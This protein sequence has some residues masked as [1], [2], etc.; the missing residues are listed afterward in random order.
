MTKAYAYASV[1]VEIQ[2]FDET[3]ALTSST[4]VKVNDK[5]TDLEVYSKEGKKI[6]ITGQIVKMDIVPNPAKN[7]VPHSCYHHNGAIIDTVP[8]QNREVHV[9]TLFT[10]NSDEFYVPMI[11]VKDLESEFYY[12]VQTNSIIS[13]GSVEE[14]YHE[15]ATAEDLA[16]AITEAKEGDLIALGA[17]ISADMSS[18]GTN[19][20][21]F[22]IPAGVNFD[23]K[24]HTI[25]IDDETGT[26]TEAS[27]AG[28]VVSV[29]GVSKISNLNI[30]GSKK[31]KAG[32]VVHGDGVDVTIE[33]VSITNCGTVGIQCAAKATAT[34][35]SISNSN[36]GSV[37]VD[38]GSGMSTDPSF[39]MVSGSL[40][41]RVQVYSEITDKEVITMPDNYKK[42]VGIG[43]NLKGFVYYT[44][45]MSKIGVAY[46][47]KDGVTYVYETQAD[48]DADE[49]VTNKQPIT[50]ESAVIAGKGANDSVYTF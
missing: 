8:I 9:A 12:Y 21:A 19:G 38:K 50:S 15:A 14:F 2:V 5:I 30:V 29:A 48:A 26:G 31:A 13:V 46:G 42:V 18:V 11:V 17:D 40:S 28:H 6:K 7:P 16:T 1:G 33:N 32:I 37:N 34:N 24:G 3:G 47:T 4:P 23:G 36:W 10:T 20:V 22:A 43:T 44:D 45:D 49:T 41:D 39:T 25:T 35:L 27:P